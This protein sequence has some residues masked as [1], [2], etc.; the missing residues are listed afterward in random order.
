MIGIFYK[1]LSEID[2]LIA[3]LD[4]VQLLSDFNPSQINLTTIVIEKGQKLNSFTYEQVDGEIVSIKSLGWIIKRKQI[5][6][7]NKPDK[8]LSSVSILEDLKHPFLVSSS[9]KILYQE[10][11]WQEFIKESNR[12]LHSLHHSNQDFL[13]H[14][15]YNF[16]VCYHKIKNYKEAT[17]FFDMGLHFEPNFHELI[18]AAADAACELSDLK[19]AKL[20]YE[21]A[22]E[23]YSKRKILDYTNY[24]EKLGIEYPRKMLENLS[25]ISRNSSF[26]KI[27]Y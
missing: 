20:L 8:S 25:G 5:Y 17:N 27:P 23:A 13:L 18:C 3:N 22:L 2:V 9:C 12:V 6:F 10:K 15:Y 1:D 21:K 4:G 11:N 7:K 26:I 19:Q 24:S 16:L 14:I